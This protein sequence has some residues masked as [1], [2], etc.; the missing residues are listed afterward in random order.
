MF[1]IN[2]DI[3]RF[4]KLNKSKYLSNKNTT[5]LYDLEREQ[6]RAKDY[7]K[8]FESKTVNIF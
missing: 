1:N 2:I 5:L 8:T 3:N 6:G 4:K 7:K